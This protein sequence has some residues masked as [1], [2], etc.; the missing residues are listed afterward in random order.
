MFLEN[1]QITQKALKWFGAND[2]VESQA[3]EPW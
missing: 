1:I 3:Q 2:F